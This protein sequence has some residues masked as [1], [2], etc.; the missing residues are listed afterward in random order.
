MSLYEIYF[1]GSLLL[2]TTGLYI[3]ASKRHLVKIVIGLEVVT[4]GVNLAIASMGI[5]IVDDMIVM[6]ALAQGM[7]AIS[8]AVA[9][10]IAALALS[11]AINIYKHYGTFD[12]RKL[13]R[14][15]W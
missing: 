8:I 13:R 9:A 14:L 1:A 12:I 2:I 3:I 15:R 4:L 6:D 10:A 5:R 7:I 11:I